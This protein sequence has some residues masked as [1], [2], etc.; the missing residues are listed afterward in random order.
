[1]CFFLR[2]SRKLFV[3][4]HPLKSAK[5]LFIRFRCDW[6]MLHD[7]RTSEKI[8]TK[9]TKKFN[10][11]NKIRGMTTPQTTHQHQLS[12]ITSLLLTK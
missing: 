10:P 1:M 8:Y 5:S 6:M 2:C 3:F 9:Q 7:L 12:T 11:I 4:A